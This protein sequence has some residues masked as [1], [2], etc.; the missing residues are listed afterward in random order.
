METN[1]NIIDY[2]EWTVPTSWNEVTLQQYEEIERLYA[3]D[4][5]EKDIRDIVHILCCKEIDEVN[6]LPIDFLEKIMELLSFV[7]TKPIEKE[8]TNKVKIGGEMYVVNVENKLKVGEYVAADTAIKADKHNYA[9]ILAILCRKENET[10]DSKFENEVLEERIKM[11]ELMPITDVLPIINFFLRLYVVSQSTTLLCSQ[12][13]EAIDH[14][15]K[16]IETLHQ[17]GEISRRCMKSQMKELRK[18]E[19]SINSI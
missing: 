8:P 10:Y 13:R 9:A 3:D 11:W 14:T 1:E 18:L 15:R 6:A 12:I 19:K 7:E 2:K 17:N 4:D 5:R 16:N